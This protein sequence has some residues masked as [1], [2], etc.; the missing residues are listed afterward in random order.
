MINII[1]FER[2][3]KITGDCIIQEGLLKEREHKRISKEW[4]DLGEKTKRDM[5]I[6]SRDIGICNV[7][8]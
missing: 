4:Q 5:V 1:K 8:L 3:G 6:G 7:F 2:G